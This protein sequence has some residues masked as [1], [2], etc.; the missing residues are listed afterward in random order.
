MFPQRNW[1]SAWLEKHCQSRFGVAPRPTALVTD[2]NFNDLVGHNASR[3]IFTNGL[4][5]GWSVSGIQNDLS[6]DLIAFNFPNGAHHSDLSG[7]FPS[8]EADTPDILAGQAQIQ[9]QLATWLEKL[10]KEEVDSF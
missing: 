5:D 7:H 6:S 10:C 9:L 1:T 8:Q 4:L 3:I 2:W